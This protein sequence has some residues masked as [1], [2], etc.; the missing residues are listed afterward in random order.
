[1]GLKLQ[2]KKIENNN[3][4]VTSDSEQIAEENGNASHMFDGNV[5]TYYHSKYKNASTAE[6]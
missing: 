6:K 3:W 1:M 4:G 2:H 5:D